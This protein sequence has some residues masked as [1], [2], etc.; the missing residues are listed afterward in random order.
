MSDISD[1]YKL[2]GVKCNEILIESLNSNRLEIIG[3]NHLALF[4][5][6]IWLEILKTRPEYDILSLA[7]REYQISILTNILGLY[8]QAFVGLRYFFERTL[9]AILF[10]AKELD[11][12]LWQ[13]G[14]RDTYWQEI[15][16]EESGLFSSKFC[17]AF[18]P[19][20]KDESTHYKSMAQ[21]V[22]RECSEFVHGN[23]AIITKIPT[24]LEFYEFLFNEWNLKAQTIRRIIL[25]SFCLRYLNLIKG[26]N[27][28][29]IE[30]HIIEEFGSLIPIN[31][32][33]S[34]TKTK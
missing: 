27:L 10:S 28:D 8:N 17:R 3:P 12:R 4:D 15:I 13:I 7:L 22:Y 26:D 11:L 6:N 1:H 18:F 25:F 19:E 29:K 23:N 30:T 21:K 33:F 5:Y 24:K 34:R 32:F 16:D 20:L 2:L 31:D 9:V 14:E